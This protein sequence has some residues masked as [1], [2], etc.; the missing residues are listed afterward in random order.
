[1]LCSLLIS[2]RLQFF[3]LVLSLFIFTF[4]SQK[5]DF[6]KSRWLNIHQGVTVIDFLSALSIVTGSA[7][8]ITCT[9]YV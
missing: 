2:L 8:V 5:I 9:W 3:L 1:M 6:Q 4:V 7:I